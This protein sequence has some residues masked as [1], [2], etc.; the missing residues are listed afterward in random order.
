MMVSVSSWGYPY[1]HHPAIERW[2][3]PWNK[4]RYPSRTSVLPVASRR[5]ESVDAFLNPLG[6]PIKELESK[7]V[8]NIYIYVYI[9]TWLIHTYGLMD[10][11]PPKFT[12]TYSS[13]MVVTHRRV[14]NKPR[15]GVFPVL[16]IHSGVIVL[17]ASTFNG[18]KKEGSSKTHPKDVWRY[19]LQG[20]WDI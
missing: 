12:E 10:A 5:T 9:H 17:G 19:R 20:S 4:P 3:F 8:Y 2:E 7:Y 14:W 11:S 13:G 15:S 18:P 1:S 6:K 16:T